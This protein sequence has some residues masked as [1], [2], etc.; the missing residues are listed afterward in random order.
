MTTAVMK[1]AVFSMKILTHNLNL[2]VW[3]VEVF[4]CNVIFE[5]YYILASTNKMLN[6]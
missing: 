2:K 3:Q 5:C 6:M 4:F 1:M